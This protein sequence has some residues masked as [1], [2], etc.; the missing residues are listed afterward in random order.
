[1]F[2]EEQVGECGGTEQT[3]VIHAVIH[4]VRRPC[5]LLLSLMKKFPN[6]QVL[7]SLAWIVKNHDIHQEMTTY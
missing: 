7:M 4:E 2:E 6:H 5:S 1:M 3:G